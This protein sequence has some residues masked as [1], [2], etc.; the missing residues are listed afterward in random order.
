MCVLMTEWP[1]KQRGPQTEGEK[2]ACPALPR[3]LTGGHVLA[4]LGTALLAGTRPQAGGPPSCSTPWS[5]FP[6]SGRPSP[7]FAESSAGTETAPSWW[8]VQDPGP[9]R[10]RVPC[11]PEHWPGSLSCLGCGLGT[12]A[13]CRSRQRRWEGTL[14]ACCST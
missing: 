3:L 11:S 2:G 10:T 6:H 7:A 13:E 14:L 4:G 8:L 9:A 1:F 5:S 12:L